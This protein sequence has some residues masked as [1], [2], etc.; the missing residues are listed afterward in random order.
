MY[1][2]K[3]I[4]FLDTPLLQR[5]RRIHQTGLAFLTSPTAVHSRFDHTL[6]VVNRCSKLI[7]EL[8]EKEECRDKVEGLRSD[9]RLAALLHDCGHGVF[10]HTSE[11][12][13]GLSDEIKQIRREDEDFNYKPQAHEILSCLIIKSD[14]FKDF[15]DKID[16]GCERSQLIKLITGVESNEL[17][18]RAE[19]L[20]SIF[21]GDKIDYIH[22]DAHFC[23]LPL[24]IDLDRLWY[25]ISIMPIPIDGRTVTKFA[26]S[27]TATEPLEQMIFHRTMLYPTLYQHQ[28]VRACDCMFKSIIEFMKRN[29]LKVKV[30]GREVTFE[31]PEDYLWATDNDFLAI[32]SSTDNEWLCKRV[33]DL[34]NRNLFHRVITIASRTVRDED[35]AEYARLLNYRSEELPEA[36]SE[37]RKIAALISGEAN[38]KGIKVVPEDIWVDLPASLKPGRDI[39]EAYVFT[40]TGKGPQFTQADEFFPVSKWARQ[41]DVHKW[42]GHVFCPDGTQ[43]A[44]APIAKGVLEA[45]FSLRLKDEA[46]LECHVKPPK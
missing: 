13:Y 21:D 10:S 11:E 28:K 43:D 41:I 2:D 33:N 17:R 19:M 9:I 1:R 38:K 44:I 23:G 36:Y 45:Q 24:R 39:E 16:P 31:H 30:G 12:I 22:R 25:G 3:E 18:Y 8:A 7:D 20:N 34:V 26:I 37:L 29:D 5:L 35:T 42:E 40:E 27:H 14:R 15:Y 4:V 32:A 46:F 6:G